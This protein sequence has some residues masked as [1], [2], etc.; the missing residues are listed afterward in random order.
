MGPEDYYHDPEWR[1]L[2]LRLLIGGVGLVMVMGALMLYV[3]PEPAGPRPPSAT[4]VFRTG[5][6]APLVVR[7]TAEDAGRTVVTRRD[8]RPYR[9]MLRDLTARCADM[10]SGE[11]EVVVENTREAI[12]KT[13]RPATWS[14]TMADLSF[15][16]ELAGDRDCH[17]AARELAARR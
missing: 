17:A 4:D 11:M 10:P 1:R 6:D 15:Q 3:W 14:R 9:S 13:G 8:V 2:Q 16:V 7:M 5:P 12:R